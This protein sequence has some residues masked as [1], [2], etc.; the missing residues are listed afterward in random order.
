MPQLQKKCHQEP[1]SVNKTL[2]KENQM[3][4]IMR[5]RS[6]DRNRITTPWVYSLELGL[7]FKPGNIVITQL[8]SYKI[9]IQWKGYSSYYSK[10]QP[11]AWD[12]H[13]VG[14]STEAVFKIWTR[15]LLV[16]GSNLS[17]VSKLRLIFI[18]FS[19]K[20]WTFEEPTN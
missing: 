15:D 4:Q 9:K 18:L 1:V 16:I 17:I 10:G 11:S 12:S 7:K 20:F 13:L 14:S 5:L 19:W 3:L 6:P 8:G 2:V